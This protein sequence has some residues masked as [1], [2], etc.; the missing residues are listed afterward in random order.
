MFNILLNSYMLHEN[1][2]DIHCHQSKFHDGH[3][4]F[5]PNRYLNISHYLKNEHGD[6]NYDNYLIHCCHKLAKL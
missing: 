4:Y 3:L 6:Y 2:R 5:H 1:S